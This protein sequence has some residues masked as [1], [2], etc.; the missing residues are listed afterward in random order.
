MVERIVLVDT[1]IISTFAVIDE[2]EFLI[3]VLD[4]D[5]L[6][7]SKNVEAE[8]E[9]AVISGHRFIKPLFKMIE[10]GII[11]VVTPTRIETTWSDGLPSSFGSGERDSIAIC[12][13]RNGIFLSNERKVRN[14]CQ[15]NEI[16]CL[17]LPILLRRSWRAG[18]R[19]RQEVTKMM[20][21]VE[22]EDNIFIKNKEAI[23]E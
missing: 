23:F 9:R 21:R 4:S 6:F 11:E 20:V 10:G 12:K 13:Q 7:I 15:R 19:S 8:L 18:V 22:K 1:N 16:P 17:D 14:Y 3:E 2:M 5:K